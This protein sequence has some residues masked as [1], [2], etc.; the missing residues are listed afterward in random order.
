MKRFGTLLHLAMALAVCVGV[1]AIAPARQTLALGAG[2]GPSPDGNAAGPVME[3]ESESSYP[4]WVGNTRVTIYNARDVL[5]NGTVSYNSSTNTLTLKN[6]SIKKYATINSNVNVGL[7]FATSKAL[8]IKLVGNN[9]IA[10]PSRNDLAY[11]IFGPYSTASLVICG[12]GRL[13]ANGG[14]AQYYSA[15][16]KTGKLA[17]KEKA[18]V[19][20]RGGTVS[21]PSFTQAGQ[22]E[23]GSFGVIV[24]QKISMTGSA[25]LAAY[26]K[27]CA[28]FTPTPLKFGS[29]YSSLM[30]AGSSS[31]SI[32][33]TKSKLADRSFIKY[34]YI[35]IGN[36]ADYYKPA[37]VK[38]T[39]ASSATTSI[40]LGWNTLT[41]NCTGYQL[42]LSVRSNFPSGDATRLY[43][44]SNKKVDGVTISSLAK[45]TKFYVRV[46]GINK[47]GSKTYYG[48]WS[49]TKALTT[50]SA[51]AG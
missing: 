35:W 42:Q 8:T 12:N 28:F 11:G 6:A 20:A 13:T 40:R 16:I 25:R 39:S 2:F 10:A 33:A 30:K 37:K 27:Q 43:T 41:K 46:R 36:A 1:V 32:A 31:S 9:T 23:T 17:I 24:D 45:K 18:V 21:R 14:S 49:A 22:P 48:P 5:G 44:T 38:I 3:A 4:I 34:K 15:G 29:G 26:G 47:R 51:A 19:V 7:Y 50:R